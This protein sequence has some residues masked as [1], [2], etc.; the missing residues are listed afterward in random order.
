[1]IGDCLLLIYKPG[2]STFQNYNLSLKPLKGPIIFL[3]LL[4]HIQWVN[5]AYYINAQKKKV[6]TLIVGSTMFPYFLRWVQDPNGG[7]G[8]LDW[9]EKHIASFV[10]IAGPMVGVPKALTAMLSGETRDTMSL[11]SFGAYL[12]EKFFSRRERANLMRTW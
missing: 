11:G 1:M 10:N 2:T 3:L 4:L 9:T 5:K 8:G 12:L 7:N 6:L